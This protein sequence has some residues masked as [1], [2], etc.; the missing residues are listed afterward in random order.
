[1]IESNSQEAS[2]KYQ[3]R[4]PL[5]EKCIEPTKKWAEGAE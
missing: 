4:Y 5:V 1:M 2:T 3:E